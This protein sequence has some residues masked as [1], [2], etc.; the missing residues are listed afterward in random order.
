MEYVTVKTSWM[1]NNTELMWRQE[2]LS[3]LKISTTFWTKRYQ[4]Q[5]IN[6]VMHT[7]IHIDESSVLEL[8][9]KTEKV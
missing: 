9:L 6:N 1:V 8:P 3:N 2:Q 7:E 5:T 4:L